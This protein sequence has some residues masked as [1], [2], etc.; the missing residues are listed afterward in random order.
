MSTNANNNQENIVMVIAEPVVTAEEFNM[1]VL[2]PITTADLI[3]EDFDDDDEAEFL[4]GVLEIEQQIESIILSDHP[5]NFLLP[6]EDDL[7]PAL[8][9]LEK[10]DELKN[11]RFGNRTL[12][13]MERR[14]RGQNKIVEEKLTQ[15]EK[16]THPDY[17]DWCCPKCLNYYK[18]AKELKKHMEREI[19]SSNHTRLVVGS[20]TKKIPTPKFFHTT[21]LLSPVFQRAEQNKQQK[22]IEL[23]EEDYD[24]D[25]NYYKDDEEVE[26]VEEVVL[27]P[28]YQKCNPPCEKKRYIGTSWWKQLGYLEPC[29]CAQVDFEALTEE[30]QEE[31]I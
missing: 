24:E 5:E 9:L 7:P 26:E 22:L 10:I 13:R 15:L 8:K 14:V 28:L 20:T 29:G 6:T 30:E 17:K 31:I 21:H 12:A 25:F 1:D 3:L 23:E 11:Y 19:C 4:Q 27:P 16:S 18:G 2:M